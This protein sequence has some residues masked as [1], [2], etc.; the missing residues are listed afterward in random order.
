[1]SSSNDLCSISMSQRNSDDLPE[2]TS[3]DKKGPVLSFHNV[4]YH[5]KEK[6]CFPFNQKTTEEKELWNINGIMKPGLNAIVGPQGGGKSRLLDILAARKEPRVLYENV[7][8][9]EV[10]HPDNFQ[11]NS[12]YVVQDDVVMSTLTVRENMWFLASLRLPTTMSKKRKNKRIKKV[13]EKLGLCEVADSKVI[14]Q[15]L[16]VKSKGERKMICIGMEL[17]LDPSILFLDEP[18]TGL[19]WNTAYKVIKLLKSLSEQGRTI[20]FSIYQPQYSIVQL[21]DSLT[22]LASGKLMYHGPAKMA[23][24][25]FKSAGYSCEHY[26]NPAEVFFDVI[27]GIIKQKSEANN[28]EMPSTNE[29]SVIEAFYEKSPICGETK[30]ELER[31]S[32]DQNKKSLF[33]EEI[34][35]VTSFG[36]QLIGITWRSFQN[37]VGRPQPWIK[38]IISTFILGIIV[39]ATF[40]WLKND[41]TEI[42]NRAAV[43]FFLMAHQCFSSMSAV[44]LFVVQKQLFLH[45][46]ISGYYRVSSY[47]LGNILSDLLARRFLPSFIFTFIV[48]FMVGSKPAVEAFFIMI[49]TLMM[50]AFSS[51]SMSLA[52]GI[53]HS[54][55]TITRQVMN[56]YFTFMLIFLG[57]TLYFGSMAPQI[58]WLQYFSIPYYGFTALQHN[59]FLGRYF[60]QALNITH[61]NNCPNYIICSGEE[62]L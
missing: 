3:S 32:N 28:T 9:H 51:I 13:I 7:W 40:L 36:H 15:F 43:L 57:L 56:I 35:Y 46:H 10:P 19:D 55:V 39:G 50:M 37:L 22:I 23:L 29:K 45:E 49:F 52:I 58:L 38:Q 8:V 61:D 12:G 17:I 24:E 60:C 1:M 11:C 44:K 27:N 47:F 21:F 18:T 33:R 42:Q 20:I 5:V 41:C 16:Y 53:S 2:T 25:Y 59:E 26:A 48:Y 31:L 6:K 30:S 4:S 14:Y 34:T 54:D 62:F